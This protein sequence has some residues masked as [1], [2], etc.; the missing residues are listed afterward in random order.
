M[1]FKKEIPLKDG[2]VLLLRSLGAQDAQQALA[3]CRKTAGETLNLGDLEPGYTLLTL[4]GVSLGFGKQAGG[5][6][7]NHYPKG[8]R[9]R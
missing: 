7:K 3:V 9:R 1:K 5:V 2:E 6:M 4:C 8:L